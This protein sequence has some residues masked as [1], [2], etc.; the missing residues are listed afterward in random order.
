MGDDEAELNIEEL[1][2]N[3]TF[4]INPVEV[5][6]ICAATENLEPVE[7]TEFPSGPENDAA[8]HVE[9]LCPEC[10][11]TKT[12]VC[13]ACGSRVLVLDCTEVNSTSGKTL[14]CDACA[15][16]AM[17]EGELVQCEHCSEYT[18]STT[19]VHTDDGY[20]STEEWCKH[21]VD[22]D[23]YF[24][25]HCE[26]YSTD[27][28]VVHSTE[29]ESDEFWCSE[30]VEEAYYCDDCYEYFQGDDMRI[31]ADHTI[32]P[33]CFEDHWGYCDSCDRLFHMD[34]LTTT[35]NGS[36]CPRCYRDYEEEGEEEESSITSYHTY[37]HWCK[38]S[39]P[40]ESDHTKLYLGFELESG[41]LG[42]SSDAEE[43]ATQAMED[44]DQLAVCQHD[45]SIP[46]YGFELISHPC[47]LRYHKQAPWKKTFD[48]MISAGLR[49]HDISGCGLHVH[50]TRDFLCEDKWSLVNWF[51]AK[52]KSRFEVLARRRNNH[53][54]VFKQYVDPREY[55][56]EGSL[57]KDAST[58]KLKGSNHYDAVNFSSSTTVEFRMCKGTLK[59]STV[60]ATL[61]L[62]D[63][64][65]RFVKQLKVAQVLNAGERSPW[66]AFVRYLEQDPELYK[67]LLDYMQNRHVKE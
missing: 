25:E 38:H 46:D 20:R 10:L 14:W 51:V 59:Y 35:D 13:S 23:A 31:D 30:C 28:H 56:E 32:C 19:T 48:N 16:K 5:C 34:D 43:A 1:Q 41:G 11:R 7:L 45:C 61:E 17:Q 42:D 26:E 27:I 60:M 50:V 53:F 64:L 47:T 29:G 55:P 37:V 67:E 22:E 65:V 12:I 33:G 2:K 36:Y 15:G 8:V 49:S 18:T 21:C 9:Y 63:G 52:Y 6:S 57:C 24:C 4:S 39:L 3:S 40:Q 62:F 58:Y 66:K 44:C 54:A